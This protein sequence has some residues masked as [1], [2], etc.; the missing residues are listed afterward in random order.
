[1]AQNE[2]E[3]APILHPKPQNC[4]CFSCLHLPVTGAD[5]D[6]SRLKR[7]CVWKPDSELFEAA[8][9]AWQCSSQLQLHFY[10]SVRYVL[11]SVMGV[12]MGQT[13]AHSCLLA[14]IVRYDHTVG[15]LH[16]SEGPWKRAVVFWWSSFFCLTQ[17]LIPDWVKLSIQCP[18]R[19]GKIGI[20]LTTVV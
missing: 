1:M 3:P 17:L 20:L 2:P 12:N 10:P 11:V 15:V 4:P 14:A 16:W 18:E 19:R 7:L 8:A 5:T 9:T 6:A 13:G